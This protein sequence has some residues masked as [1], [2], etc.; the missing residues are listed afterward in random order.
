MHFCVPC[1]P[2]SHRFYAQSNDVVRRFFCFSLT[3]RQAFGLLDRNS[4]GCCCFHCFVGCWHLRML[5]S[6]C[7]FGR[8]GG[9]GMGGGRSKMMYQMHTR[10]KNTHHDTTPLCITQDARSVLWVRKLRPKYKRHKNH[11]WLGLGLL[12]PRRLSLSLFIPTRFIHHESARSTSDAIYNTT[13][14]CEHFFE[15]SVCYVLCVK[16]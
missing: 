2:L 10:H 8:G 3:L 6:L 9:G 15:T 11:Y 13:A 16:C 5:L 4:G 1:A 7:V 14:K 12:E